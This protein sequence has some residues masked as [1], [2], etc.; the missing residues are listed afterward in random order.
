MK[1]YK[2]SPEQHPT[3][4]STAISPGNEFEAIIRRWKDDQK[5]LDAL[6]GGLNSE[7]LVVHAKLFGKCSSHSD[8]KVVRLT[9][10][11]KAEY[12]IT[13]DSLQMGKNSC[14]L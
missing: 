4:S 7:E 3:D 2:R 10:Y 9:P 13:T 8:R 14:T 6:V 12:L 11:L 1:D 5:G